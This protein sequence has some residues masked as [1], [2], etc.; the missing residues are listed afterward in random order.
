MIHSPELI[1]ELNTARY[2]DKGRRRRNLFL[3]RFLSQESGDYRLRGSKQDEAYKIV[4]SWADLEAKG[5]LQRRKESSV[6]AE[7]LTQVFGQA[8]GYTLFSKGLDTW[9]LE[10]KLALEGGTADAAIGLFGVGKEPLPRAIVE[11]KGPTVNVDRDRSQGRTPVQ[12]CW[13]YLNAAPDCPWGIVCNIVSFRLYHR[14]Q[15]SRAYQLFTLQDLTR[16][17]TFREFYYLLAKGGLLPLARGQEPR[18]DAL[19]AKTSQRQREVGDE[20]YVSYHDNRVALVRHLCGPPHGKPL[21]RAIHVTQRLLDRIVFVA[22]CEDRGLLPARLIHKACT[23]FRP[24]RR[25]TNPR[26]QNFLDLFHAVDQGDTS[27]GISPFN[28]NLFK[29]DSEVDDLQLDDGW[30][31]AFE[32]IGSYDFTDEVNVD[33]LGHLFERSVNDLERLRLGGLFQTQVE[34]TGPKMAKSAERK[35]SGIYY[36]PPQFTQ[37]IV[38]NTIAR[39]A[40]QRLDALARK[41]KLDSKALAASRADPAHAKYWRKCLDVLR[42]LKIAD[43]ACGSGAFLIQAYDVL[44]ELYHDVLDHVAFHEGYKA[45]QLYEQVPD[46][47]LRDNLFGV[48]LSPEAVEITQLALWIR[49]A[50]TGRTLANLSANIVCGNSLVGDKAV[51]PNAMD[52]REVFPGIFSRPEGGFDCV[53]GNPPWERMKLQEREFFDTV[54]PKIAG[55]VDAASRRKLI[56]SLEKRNPDLHKRYLGAKEA[57]EQTLN[58]IRACGRYPL[59][60][61]G[62]TNTYAVFAELAHS[63]VSPAGV[64]GLL[65]PSGVAT[66]HTTKE[67]FARLTDPNV[68]IGL[69]DFENRHK[70]FPDVDGRFKFCVL[71]FGGSRA[72]AK[73]ADFVFFAHEMEDL[74][75]KDR[76]IALTAAD[77]KLLNP[78]TRTCPIFRGRRD[79]E[80]TKAIYRR[81]PIF[82][83]H[84]RKEGGNPWDVRY[85]TMFH[86][87]NDAELFRTARQLKAQKCV[88]DGACWRK[89]KKRYLPLYEAKMV[90]AYDHRAAS[91]VVKADNWMRQGQT[92]ETSLVEHQNPEF[93]VE[94]RWWVAE[95]E[96]SER[97]GG[98]PLPAFIG[99]KDITSSTNERTMIAA[100]IPWSAVTNHLPLAITQQEPRL[101]LCLLANLNSFVLDYVTRQKTGGV[102][103]NF[104]IVEQLPVFPPDAYAQKCP[105]ER[106]RTLQDW[107][108]QRVLK[109][110]C[111]SNDMIPLAEAAGFDPPVHK[112]KPDER[113]DLLAEMDAAYMLLYGIER[114]DLTYILSTFGEPD[115]RGEVLLPSGSPSARILEHYDRLRG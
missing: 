17:E 25:V 95:T 76:H 47:I 109:L 46:F 107:I 59:T 111:T 78:N 87:T 37:F 61:K 93:C 66:D 70:V 1:P 48:D 90:Q 7:F 24:F 26:W 44:E 101:N 32:D 57:A 71:L 5:R 55:A 27:N 9:D 60:G 16:E 110:T 52:W 50:R 15:G 35:K 85:F 56:A 75:D 89:G 68:L 91:V 92:A 80:L 100:A 81:V 10:P 103:L 64:V 63:I 115:E 23:Q 69:Y 39:L 28:G 112:W 102:T 36:T 45:E 104:F 30:T 34:Q 58:Y 108:A 114:D 99:F 11:L 21:E 106:K 41:H 82:V 97:M 88:R 4:C 19:L 74:K 22:F 40:R 84:N 6:E 3:A 33:V 49:S 67:F 13:D 14:S 105:W 113:A 51:H 2:G 86:Q 42:R 31:N 98:L 62:D 20:L 73:A 38:H 53:I 72:E 12:Q 29:P 79:V 8:L 18:A 83:D 65:V 54:A 96:V 77:M 43:P 94:P